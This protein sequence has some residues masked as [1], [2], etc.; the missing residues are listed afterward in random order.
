MCR[1]HEL[2]PISYRVLDGWSVV[3][4]L[5]EGVLVCCGAMCCTVLWCI[6]CGVGDSDVG[7]DDVSFS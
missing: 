4:L 1:T 2:F 5:C 6:V 3:K 7:V